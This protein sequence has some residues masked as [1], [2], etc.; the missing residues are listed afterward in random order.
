[1]T[2]STPS[3]ALPAK[4]PGCFR[5]VHTADWHLGKPLAEQDRTE[6]HRR[7]LSF[8][9]ETLIAADA[10]ALVIAGD[11]FDCATP[12]QAAVR[13]YFDFLAELYRR[14]HC[15]AVVGAGNH[16]SPSHLEA[17]RELLGVL[18]TRV[19]ASLPEN[20]AELLIPL[21]SAEAPALVVAAVPYLRERDLR[22]GRLGQ[23]AAEI[24]RDLREGLRRRY[25]EVAAAAAPWRARGVPVLAMGHLCALGASVT[26]ESEREIHVGGLGSIGA[27]AFPED[28]AYVALGHLHRAQAVGGRAH[29][30]YAG[31]PLALSF[32][33]ASDAKELRLL[34]FEAGALA[35][36]EAI[37]V[38]QPRRLVQLR[39]AQDGLEAGLRAFTPPPSDLPPWVEVVVEKGTPANDLY[40]T[41][42]DWVEGRPFTVVK[43]TVEREGAL[44]GLSLADG[45]AEAEAGELLADPKA[46]FRQR[47]DQEPG[48]DPDGRA[49]LETAFAELCERRLEE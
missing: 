32:S 24:E 39:V 41:V 48:L 14:T 44:P 37:P 3:I 30:R 38:P 34:D 2:V 17:P 4:R 33:E 16:D 23:S 40:R 1:M 49:A 42:Q 10:D 31:S 20:P 45:C 46:V 47:L 43:V 27:D 9:L 26:P 6:E 35:L 13:L 8:L 15:V 29:I 7:F 11:V 22:A 5:V 19:A 12:P 36:N 28:F 21:P 25:A 18:R